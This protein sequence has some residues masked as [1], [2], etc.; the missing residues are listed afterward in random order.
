MCCTWLAENTGPKYRE[1]FALWAPSHNFFK[2]QYPLQM[3]AQY[4]E[5]GPLAAE[6]GPVVWSTTRTK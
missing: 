5:L 4:G 6:I 1:K 2:Q 3:S